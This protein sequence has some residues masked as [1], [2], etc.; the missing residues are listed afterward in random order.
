MFKFF[1]ISG[2]VICTSGLCY[3]MM[4]FKSKSHTLY[5][6]SGHHRVSRIIIEQPIDQPLPPVPCRQHQHRFHSCRGTIWTDGRKLLMS[7]WRGY[8]C[9]VAR[10]APVRCLLDAVPDAPSPPDKKSTTVYC[11][12]FSGNTDRCTQ[13]IWVRRTPKPPSGRPARLLSSSAQ[14]LQY[15]AADTSVSACQTWQ[16][17]DARTVVPA[18]SVQRKSP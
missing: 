18:S 17:A 6:N 5:F 10:T 1:M 14:S 9:S 11:A 8:K 13:A 16:T 7:A 2:V 3:H 4:L 15:C 12:G